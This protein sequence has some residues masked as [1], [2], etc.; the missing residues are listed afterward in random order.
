MTKCDRNDD[1]DDDDNKIA[2][3]VLLG[4]IYI[5]KPCDVISLSVR[6]SL[7]LHVQWPMAHVGQCWRIIIIIII[8]NI[9]GV[10]SRK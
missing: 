9:E 4:H 1:G 10:S 8:I 6:V 7:I 3:F 2:Y 5:I